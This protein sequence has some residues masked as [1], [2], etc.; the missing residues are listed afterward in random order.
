MTSTVL[1]VTVLL[2]CVSASIVALG[3]VG[4]EVGMR[5]PTADE[6]ADRLVTETVTVRYRAPE[7]ANGSRTIH[8][9]R[10][11]L[12]ALLVAR[13]GKTDGG[14]SA[15]R[16]RDATD[17]NGFE[18]R[19]AAAVATGLDERT[20]I[21]A[22]VPAPESRERG[23]QRPTS[24]RRV[25]NHRGGRRAAGPIAVTGTPNAPRVPRRVGPH[26]D[27]DPRGDEGRRSG[28]TRN[29]RTVAVGVEPPRNVDVATA[30]I[31]HP[32]PSATGREASV[33][34]V[35]RRW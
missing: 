6:A 22:T 17:V 20:R 18:A 21:D 31:T 2:L 32:A 16:D 14:R 10:A 5:G 30:V 28:A 27:G 13:P 9:T 15:T 35:V 3:G 12:L 34:I 26:A 33:R 4:G 19:A 25:P 23:T 1:D 11:E 29:E 24:D 7:A 8:A